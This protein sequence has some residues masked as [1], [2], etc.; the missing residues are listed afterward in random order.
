MQL[1][2]DLAAACVGVV[3]NGPDFQSLLL[4]AAL[5]LGLDPTRSMDSSEVV[6]G[7]GLLASGPLRWGAN[8]VGGPGVRIC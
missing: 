5:E 4:E 6:A 8:R 7:Q 3:V 2:A 1:E